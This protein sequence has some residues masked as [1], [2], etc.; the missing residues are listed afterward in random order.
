MKHLTAHRWQILISNTDLTDITDI[1]DLVDITDL[2]DFTDLVY[3]FINGIFDISIILFE[4]KSDYV[5]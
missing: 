2:T 4:R 5:F 1:A 3:Y